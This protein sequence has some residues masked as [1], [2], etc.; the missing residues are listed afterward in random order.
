MARA[1]MVKGC[2]RYVLHQSKQEMRALQ[3]GLFMAT[4]TKTPIRS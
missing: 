2:L 1:A 4:L 3:A